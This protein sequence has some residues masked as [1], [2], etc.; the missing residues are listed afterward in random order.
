MKH[1]SIVVPRGAALSGI[2]VSRHFFTE[3]NDQLVREG[4]APLF[5]VQLVGATASVQLND[6]LF[7]IHTDTTITQLQQTDLIIIPALYDLEK[8]LDDNK[9]LI[10]WIEQRYAGGAE[11]ASLCVGAFLLARTGLL[12]GRSCTTHWK[13]ASIFR[14]MF[15]EVYLVQEKIITDESGIYS[16]GGGFSFLNL[17]VYLADRKSVV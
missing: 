15:P 13:A 6:G 16:S 11:I 9:E 17:L 4:K 3:I 1:L 10:A 14:D 5:S 8:N 2:E 12:K 7:T